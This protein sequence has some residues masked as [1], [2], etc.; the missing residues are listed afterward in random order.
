MNHTYPVD[1]STLSVTLEML[2]GGFN[3]LVLHFQS[4]ERFE[5]FERHL[6]TFGVFI[7]ALPSK[8]T[9][10]TALEL[11]FAT[12]PNISTPPIPAEVAYPVPEGLT[13]RI[14]LSHSGLREALRA[15]H[16]ALTER[17]ALGGIDLMKLVRDHS[18]AEAIATPTTETRA[19]KT[20]NDQLARTAPPDPST[21]PN[22]FFSTSRV[23][24]PA[25][26]AAT[27]TSSA[28]TLPKQTPL[29]SAGQRP[30]QAARY[31]GETTCGPAPWNPTSRAQ[32]LARLVAPIAAPIDDHGPAEALLKLA[33]RCEDGVVEL[34]ASPSGQQFLILFA[35]GAPIDVQVWPEPE[36]A[37]LEQLLYNSDELTSDQVEQVRAQ[38]AQAQM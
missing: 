9:A 8:L 23:S 21:T 22:P 35:L 37:G 31:R 20:T 5:E 38:M 25:R 29:Q 3:R 19:R 33:A 11:F 15:F 26:T 14:D 12:E 24:S 2:E 10:G 34:T 18:S 6:W 16:E 4:V 13:I 7:V 28:S 17:A 32:A 27:S 1:P 36:A 30:P